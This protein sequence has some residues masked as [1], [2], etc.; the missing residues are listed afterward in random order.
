MTT[1]EVYRGY[2]LD[3]VPKH[4]GGFF[5]EIGAPGGHRP[6]PTATFPEPTAAMDEARR[7]IDKGLLV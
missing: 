5:V 2:K 3:I 1:T 6:F 4:N 7:I